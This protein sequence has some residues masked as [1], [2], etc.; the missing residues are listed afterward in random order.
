LRVATGRY[1]TIVSTQR[2][3]VQACARVSE[4]AAQGSEPEFEEISDL[5]DAEASKPL[6]HLGAHPP[7]PLDRQGCEKFDLGPG[8]HLCEAVGLAVGARNL[9]HELVGGDADRAAETHP[10]A[11]RSSDRL[12]APPW[13]PKEPLGAAEI[14]ERFVQAQPLDERAELPKDI[15]DLA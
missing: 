5:V 8:Q 1:W 14:Q 13:G 10:L 11:H 3:P 12:G 15:E 9:G 6:A 7:K 4:F 2:E